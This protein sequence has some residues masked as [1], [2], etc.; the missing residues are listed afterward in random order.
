MRSVAKMATDLHATAIHLKW[1]VLRIKLLVV[2]G[3]FCDK[4]AEGSVL[5]DYE[6][7]AVGCD[8]AN[9]ENKSSLADRPLVDDSEI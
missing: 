4:G 2:R 9:I 8:D 6:P 1:F 3:N 7:P 5:S